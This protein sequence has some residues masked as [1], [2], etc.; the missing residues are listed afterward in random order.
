MKTGPF[1]EHSNQLWDISGVPLWQKVNSGLIKKYRAEVCY[2]ITNGIC[3][4]DYCIF[5]KLLLEDYNRILETCFMGFILL[6]FT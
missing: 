5:L 1:A 4:Q 3:L 2:M 6:T